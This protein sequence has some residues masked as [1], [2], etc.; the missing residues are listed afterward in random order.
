MLFACWAKL[1]AVWFTIRLCSTFDVR[2]L[3]E[4]SFFFL[5]ETSQPDFV[6]DFVLVSNFTGKDSPFLFSLYIGPFFSLSLFSP[7]SSPVV[8]TRV[9][10]F[11][12]LP[13]SSCWDTLHGGKPL[14]TVRTILH[15]LRI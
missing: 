14:K 5:S 11:V 15:K 6:L 10:I 12:L 1:L 13:P 2:K 4:I 9:A 3:C 7:F 8:Y